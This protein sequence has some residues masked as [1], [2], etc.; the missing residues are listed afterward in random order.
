MDTL[1]IEILRLILSFLSTKQ[2]KTMRMVNLNFKTII[3][4]LFVPIYRLNNIMKYHH[5]NE[6][7]R[8]SELLSYYTMYPRL[9]GNL[10]LPN[11]HGIHS[12][13]RK[14]PFN[15][16]VVNGCREKSIGFLYIKLFKDET[17]YNDLYTKRKI[18]YCV[19][20]FNECHL[21]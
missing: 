20:H 19:P 17:I 10:Y 21:H 18:P 9:W 4:T 5:V 13:F 15:R 14:K 12:L 16:C 7:R 3:G 8:V 1:P 11:Q 6:V 2:K